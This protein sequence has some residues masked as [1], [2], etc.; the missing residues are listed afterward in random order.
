MQAGMESARAT[1]AGSYSGITHAR[2]TE[3]PRLSGCPLSSP[4]V[5]DNGK[6]HGT[7]RGGGSTSAAAA[8]TARWCPLAGG[9][10]SCPTQSAPWRPSAAALSRTRPRLAGGPRPHAPP[11]GCSPYEPVGRQRHASN[12]PNPILLEVPTPLCHIQ[13]AYGSTQQPPPSMPARRPTDRQ[14]LTS[15]SGPPAASGDA[16]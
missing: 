14:C 16:V 5:H 7:E 11:T 15:G 2:F 3:R 12:G 4:L 8:A 10:T 1:V 6:K 13:Y 9:A